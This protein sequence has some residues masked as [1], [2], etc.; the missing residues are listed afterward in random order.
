MTVL[1]G[2]LKLISGFSFFP[3]LI[4]TWMVFDMSSGHYKFGT[5]STKICFHVFYIVTSLHQTFQ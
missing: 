3:I 2:S 4:Y 5:I 1:F